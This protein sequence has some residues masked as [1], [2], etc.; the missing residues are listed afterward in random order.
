MKKRILNKNCKFT[1]SCLQGTISQTQVKPH[2]CKN[3]TGNFLTTETALNGNGICSI[4]TA[5]AQ[6]VTKS[7][8]LKTAKKW[9]SGIEKKKK[10]NGTS[11]LNKDAKMMCPVGGTIRVQKPLPP[12]SS[13]PVSSM[14]MLS[15][16]TGGVVGSG[17]AATV[18]GNTTQS[19]ASPQSKQIESKQPEQF[20]QTEQ[21]NSVSEKKEP[22]KELTE[23]PKQ[24]ELQEQSAGTPDA[25]N[26]CLCSYD[27]CGKAASCP[28]VIASSTINTNGAAAK[29][30]NNSSRKEADYNERAN[31]NM[32]KEKISWNN[33]AHH[34][35]SINA[36]YCR[37]P[38][39]V[40][41]G[42]YFGYDINCEENCYFLPC[43]ESGDG[44]GKKSSHYKKAQ[45]YEVMH[46]SGLQWHVGQHSYRINIPDKIK[47]K[48]PELRTIDCYNDE[49]NKDIKKILSACNQRFNDGCL[50][51]NYEVHKSWFF[52]KM[53]A[54]SEKI[55]EYL[56]LF[57]GRAKDSFPYFVS[58]EA[59]RYAYEIPRSGKVML[60]YQTATKWNL[61]KY[62]YTNYLKNEKIQLNFLAAQD[63]PV[64]ENHRPETIKKMTLFC[65]NVTCFL[66]AD[67][68]KSF[69]LPFQ[70]RVNYQY[71]CNSE[72]GKIGSHFSALLAEQKDAGEEEYIAPKAMVARRLKECGLL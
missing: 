22:E 43:W 18:A 68:K 24:K 50:A 40:K 56:D 72:L 12:T 16:P 52:E 15:T 65:E 48:Y 17:S 8:E 36:A 23:K 71:I 14:A 29:L 35:I 64:A 2:R 37:Y 7:C 11:L 9:I 55:E 66:I 4:L 13:M 21:A 67:E 42:N 49:I 44:Y 27:T 25:I 10:I 46:A 45:A 58:M 54:L 5:A 70:Y 57:G 69:Q 38:E 53:N 33:Q 3:G 39:L 60:L 1:C 61:K 6:G 47:E 20:N 41:L 62:Q 59:L 32:E 34:M 19:K 28:Y 26:L 63:I 30:R 31:R 51:E